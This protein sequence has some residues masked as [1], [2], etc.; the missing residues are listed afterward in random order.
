MKTILTCMLLLLAVTG[1]TQTGNPFRRAASIQLVSF[2]E[3]DLSGLMTHDTITAHI[4]RSFT[5]S[6]GFKARKILSKQETGVL[7]GLFAH[8]SR[9]LCE[10]GCFRI[11]HAVLFVDTQGHVYDFAAFCFTEGSLYMPLETGIDAYRYLCPEDVKRVQRFF[12]AQGIAVP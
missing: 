10:A 4:F 1:H 9:Q 11:S 12:L 5:N 2:P 8:H 7:A 6:P 3:M